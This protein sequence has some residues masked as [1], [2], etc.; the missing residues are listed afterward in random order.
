MFIASV[1]DTYMNFRQTVWDLWWTK[2]TGTGF[3]ITYQH[4]S[5]RTL[6]S[7]MLTHNQH[8]NKQFLGAFTQGS[9]LWDIGGGDWTGQ[10]VVSPC[11]GG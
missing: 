7:L 8:E 5:I 10:N 3:L 2:G 11:F 1:K 6:H 4:H 9:V